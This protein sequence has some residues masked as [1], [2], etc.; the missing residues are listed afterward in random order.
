MSRLNN[1]TNK[2][3]GKHL[4]YEKRIKIEALSNAGLKSEEIG[5]IIGCSGR[6]VCNE[7]NKKKVELLNSDL[8]T[9][10]EYSADI[11]QQKHEYAGTNKGTHLKIGNNYELV[12][13]IERLIIEEIMSPYAVAEVIKQ[14]GQFGDAISYKTI[15]NY[16][17]MGLFPNLTNKHL[18][19]KKIKVKENTMK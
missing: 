8:T 1:N 18:P 2:G 4:N 19:V 15:Y 6:V 16:I 5:A 9:R 12:N 17:D 11:G 13:E 14:S 7:L 3:K 10:I